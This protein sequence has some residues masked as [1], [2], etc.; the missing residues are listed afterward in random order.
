M[1]TTRRKQA[2]KSNRHSAAAKC[3]THYNEITNGARAA[4][5]HDHVAK[6]RGQDIC[7]G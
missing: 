4:A 3:V 1:R 7:V 5:L 6:S 2:K